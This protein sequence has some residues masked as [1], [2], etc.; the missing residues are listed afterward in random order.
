MW[1]PH[2][3]ESELSL[4]ITDVCLPSAQS[5]SPLL[6]LDPQTLCLDV[7]PEWIVCI[8]QQKKA[9]HIKR[10]AEFFIPW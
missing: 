4:P 10:T 8:T 7:V 9:E 3:Q 5:Q 6:S 1:R 2:R